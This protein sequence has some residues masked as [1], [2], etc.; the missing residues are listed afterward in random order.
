MVIHQPCLSVRVFKG[1]GAPIERKALWNWGSFRT[2]LADQALTPKL[3]HQASL[4]T[5]VTLENQAVALNSCSL[6]LRTLLNANL[7]G[8]IALLILLSVYKTALGN[9]AGKATCSLMSTVASQHIHEV[10]LLKQKW[11]SCLFLFPQTRRR[12]KLC[13]NT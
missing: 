11:V 6:V 5:W 13:R 12:A 1:P 9:S 7:Q 8:L 4:G 3:R 2:P 10:E